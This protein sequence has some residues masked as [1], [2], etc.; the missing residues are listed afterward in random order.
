APQFEPAPSSLLPE[1]PLLR[2][3][4]TVSLQPASLPPE[5][6]SHTGSIRH[7][8]RT[9]IARVPDI[10]NRNPAATVGLI[11]RDSHPQVVPVSTSGA[12]VT[13]AK[14]VRPGVTK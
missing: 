3:S 1:T 9:L 10:L 2:T 7:A 13:Q 4:R 8:R 11:D 6:E 14:C 12:G 5:R